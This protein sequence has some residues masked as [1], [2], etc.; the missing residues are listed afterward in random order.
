MSKPIR[1]SG[2]VRRAG[3][4]HADHAAGRAGQDRVLAAEG[5][6]FGQAAVRLH[7]LEPGALAQPAGDPVDIAAQDRR[8]IGVD[9]GRVAAPDQLDQRRHLMADRDL[10]EAELAGDR[11]QPRLMIGE[12]P[13][14]HQ[15]DGQRVEALCA[16]DLEV[17]AGALLVERHGPPFRRRRSAR[18]SRPLSRRAS[19]AGRCG[20]RR[21]PA[22]PG[23]RSAARRRSRG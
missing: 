2:T 19:T 3:R 5:A 20:G 4:D 16:Q 17:S 23:S 13:A 21:F 10:G 14:V 1:R 9:H 8:Q 6:G 12:A 18:R 22:A 11:R 7:E 15:H